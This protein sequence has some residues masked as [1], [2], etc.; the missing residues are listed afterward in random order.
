MWNIPQWLDLLQ[1]LKS[2]Q[3][4]V[5]TP[6]RI[7]ASPKK[8]RPRSL[9]I[10]LAD[11]FELALTSKTIP[12]RAIDAARTLNQGLCAAVAPH[13]SRCKA[14]ASA[15]LYKRQFFA[16]STHRDVHG[17]GFPQPVAKT[18]QISLV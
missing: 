7:A 17:E 5:T 13:S 2:C 10:T 6:K 3:T 15:V 14:F 11:I 16:I 9:L 12:Q 1:L 4:K 8:R 18:S